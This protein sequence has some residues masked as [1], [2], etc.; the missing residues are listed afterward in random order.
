VPA[1]LLARA[2]EVLPQ[3]LESRTISRRRVAAARWHR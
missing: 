3:R 2:D 1:S